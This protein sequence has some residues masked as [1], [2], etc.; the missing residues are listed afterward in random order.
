MSAWVWV[1]VAVVGGLG[2][3]GRFAFDR[4]V[5][6]GTGRGF[7]FGTLAVNAS[8][9]L[10]LGLFAGLSLSGTALTIAG[11]ALL[12]SYTTFSTWMLETHRLVEDAGLPRAAANAFVSLLLGFGA[13]ALGHLIGAHA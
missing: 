4:L 9:A 7:P 11:T 10:L 13:V 3:L 2:A 5:A 12:G 8:G 1:A 6:A